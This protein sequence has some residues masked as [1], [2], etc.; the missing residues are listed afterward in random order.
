MISYSNIVNRKENLNMIKNVFYPTNYVFIHRNLK[1]K[2]FT[3]SIFWQKSTFAWLQ[4]WGHAIYAMA[5]LCLTDVFFSARFICTWWLDRC[6]NHYFMNIDMW[7]LF[8]RLKACFLLAIYQLRS[9]WHDFLEYWLYLILTFGHGIG[10]W[11]GHLSLHMFHHA[12]NHDIF[13]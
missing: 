1:K 3:G 11:I 8:W 2:W 4:K 9:L 6:S 10:T 5:L 12:E 7:K 13:L